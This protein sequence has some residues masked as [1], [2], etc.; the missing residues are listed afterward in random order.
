MMKKN[1][2][3]DCKNSESKIFEVLKPKRICEKNERELMQNLLCDSLGKIAKYKA[4]YFK[5]KDYFIEINGKTGIHYHSDFTER[6]M[7][8]NC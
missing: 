4:S 5:S 1:I 2:R 8:R 3:A 7:L 6:H